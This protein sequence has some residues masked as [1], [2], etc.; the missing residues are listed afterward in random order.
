MC[1]RCRNAFSYQ[2]HSIATANGV[3]DVRNHATRVGERARGEQAR[4]E[5]TYKKRCYVLC[6]RLAD[7]EKHVHRHRQNEDRAAADK[8]R[9]WRP[10]ER[11]KDI[12]GYGKGMRELSNE[13]ETAKL[14][15]LGITM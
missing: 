15:N 8:L 6:E 3:P 4:K 5:A 1:S 10:D 12:T 7:L 11:S 2:R 9:T 13:T 14:T